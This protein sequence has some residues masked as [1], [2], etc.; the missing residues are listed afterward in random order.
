MAYDSD[1]EQYNDLAIFDSKGCDVA[2]REEGFFV[3]Q[4]NGKRFGTHGFKRN[5]ALRTDEIFRAGRYVGEIRGDRI[6]F[7]P[8]KAEM[9]YAGLPPAPMSRLKTCRPHMRFA[10]L[11]V[12][13][14]AGCTDVDF[15]GGRS[16]YEDRGLRLV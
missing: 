7:K 3:F 11:P 6:Y 12:P 14:P 2:Y 13:M 1:E 8:A 5:T 16:V 15:D 4:R 10:G 9:V